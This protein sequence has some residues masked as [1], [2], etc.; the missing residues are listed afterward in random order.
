MT[1]D[2]I[3]EWMQVIV[4]LIAV[5]ITFV[6]GIWSS[7]YIERWKMKDTQPVIVIQDDVIPI[8]PVDIEIEKGRSIPFIANRVIV[9][10]TGR[11][12]AKDCK[13]YIRSEKDNLNYRV[14]WLLPD[15]NTALTVTLNVNIPEYVD[16]CAMSIDGKYLAISNERGFKA[17]P[18]IINLINNDLIGTNRLLLPIE[19]TLIVASSNAQPSERRITFRTT[20]PPFNQNKIVT[21][22]KGSAQTSETPSSQTLTKKSKYAWL[23]DWMDKD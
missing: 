7:R 19:A 16:L 22:E 18:N 4:P 11:S 23:T 8:D 5:P 15:H 9:K 3:L 20:P 14:G 12:G 6:V 21:F 2:P 13:V 10:N 1:P 17:M